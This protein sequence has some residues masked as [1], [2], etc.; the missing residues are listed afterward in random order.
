[1]T[2]TQCDDVVGNL[3]VKSEDTAGHRMHAEEGSLTA[4]TADDKKSGY[5]ISGIK[6]HFVFRLTTNS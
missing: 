6:P 5:E 4:A 2:L 3:P 1:L